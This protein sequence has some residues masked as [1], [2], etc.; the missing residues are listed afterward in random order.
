LISNT[1]IGETSSSHTPSGY[2]PDGLRAAELIPMRPTFLPRLFAGIIDLMILAVPVSV[3]ISFLSVALGISTAFLTLNPGQTPH[4][5]LLRFGDRFIYATLAFF[6]AISWIYFAVCESSKRQATPGKRLFGLRVTDEAGAR[7]TF[8]RA[9]ERFWF[10]RA[11]VHFPYVGIYY[12]LA[13]CGRVAFAKD[14]RAV[15]DRM[16]GCWVRRTDVEIK[17]T[18]R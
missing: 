18:Q 11:L 16:A 13:D 7:V 2:G 4:E 15:H 8:W 9:S 12:F 3:F 17:V 1:S 10:G 6:V 14:G 5:I